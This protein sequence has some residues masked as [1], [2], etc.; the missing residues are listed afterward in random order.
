MVRDKIKQNNKRKYTNRYIFLSVLTSIVLAGILVIID[1]NVTG[2]LQKRITPENV[3]EN[4][5]FYTKS[6][7]SIQLDDDFKIEDYYITNKVT[8]LNRFYI[9]KKSVLWGTGQNVYG[10]L[11]NGSTSEIGEMAEKPVKIAEEVVSVDTSVNGY[12][13]IY[14]TSDGALY[15]MGSNIYGLLG[16]EF[17]PTVSYIDDCIKVTEPVLLMSDVKYARAGIECITALKEDGSVWW[18]GQYDSS[19]ASRSLP[20]ITTLSEKTIEDQNNPKKML[21]NSPTKILDNCIYST[22]G[23]WSGAAITQQGELYTWG[24]NIFGECGTGISGDDYLRVPTHVLDDVRMVWVEE[25]TFNSV[26]TDIP[27][28]VEY[29]TVYD[30]NTFVQLKDGTMM[31]SGLNLGDEERKIEVTGDLEESSS[32]SYSDT[33]VPV[34]I[35][36]KNK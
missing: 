3:S 33:F 25:V 20:D 1:V 8:G 29:D 23:N 11:G 7:E 10:Q 2:S 22:T 30:F 13:T 12:F 35:Q 6:Q 24:L 36:R 28:V 26:E 17:D 9:D 19:Y 31:A 16:Q 21:F 32:F 5:V 18:W 15:G 4:P 34:S 14:L 27:E